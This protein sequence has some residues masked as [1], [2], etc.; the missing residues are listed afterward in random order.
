M[1]FL[2]MFAPFFAF[3][4]FGFV[5]MV[6]AVA[7]IIDC[8]RIRAEW[9]W[10]FIV[11]FV[12][13]L[14]PAAYFL[15]YYGPW[16]G[17]LGRLSP[18]AAQ[19]A[20]AKR[21][22]REIEVQLQHW[23]GPSILAEAG[24]LLLSLNKRKRAEAML[25]EARDAG[26]EL[27]EY[28]LPLA[29][30][31]Q[32][33][34]KRWREAS[35]L[36]EELVA[37]DPDF[38]FGAARLALARTLDELG[39]NQRAEDELRAVLVK[40]SPPEAKVRLA[41]LLLARDEGEEAAQLLAEVRADAAGMPAY[42]RRQHKP[43]I[44][45]ARRLKAPSAALPGPKLE[46]LPPAQPVWQIAAVALGLAG[47][48]AFGVLWFLFGPEYT[49]SREMDD[50][51]GRLSAMLER[52]IP[53]KG[54][55]R[56]K[57][58]LAELELD[59]A[60]VADWLEFR[61]ALQ[62]ACSAA[63]PVSTDGVG[64]SA[65][66]QMALHTA[67]LER[68]AQLGELLINELA[69]R[70]FVLED[71]A[72]RLALVDWRFLGRQPA[73]IFEM[74]EHFRG[75]YL[76]ALGGLQQ[77]KVLVQGLGI[78]YQRMFEQQQASARA[79]VDDLREMV[80]ERTALLEITRVHLE[81]RRAELESSLDRSCLIDLQGLVTGQFWNKDDKPWEDRPSDADPSDADPGDAGPNDEPSSEPPR[82]EPPRDE[83]PRDEPPKPT[84]DG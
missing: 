52:L 50:A 21:R 17:R 37:L 32:V 8:L 19:R 55:A 68:Q 73:A 71:L 83:P 48:M 4:C 34:G 27:K 38:R 10:L 22:L 80:Q 81:A 3:G 23:R 79:K 7:A 61:A 12:P 69:L 20:E 42:L 40:R 9:F 29:S 58:D 15:V 62:R 66:E 76:V 24:D 2:W 56:S 49:G 74:P 33:E 77:D 47:L 14:G 59:E 45:A 16:A 72:R 84:G 54:E 31:L 51:A 11:L 25:L 6:L 67:N 30:V 44:R 26:A 13:V 41:R 35:S 57:T 63:V 1:N 46:G 43:W 53:L 5:P 28:A 82:D 70:D 65:D 78:E 75:G 60:A 39:E 64:T 18:G 36:L